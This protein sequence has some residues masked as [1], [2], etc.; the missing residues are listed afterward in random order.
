MGTLLEPCCRTVVA[1]SSGV[2][3]YQ[4]CACGRLKAGVQGAAGGC[5]DGCRRSGGGCG[6]GRGRLEPLKGK[7]DL[8]KMRK[9]QGERGEPGGAVAEDRVGTL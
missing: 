6:A 7:G 8:E 5:P 4:P 3:G 1:G 9:A 2:L